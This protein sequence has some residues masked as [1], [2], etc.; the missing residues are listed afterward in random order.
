M[1]SDRRPNQVWNPVFY[2][3]H[4]SLQI[5]DLRRPA[6]TLRVAFGALRLDDLF[7][8][9]LCGLHMRRRQ[10]QSH[11]QREE[12]ICSPALLRPEDSWLTD[13]SRVL[14]HAVTPYYPMSRSH[15]SHLS[16]INQEI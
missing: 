10:R 14:Y 11:K 13:D 9:S 3:W 12:K 5:T 8:I 4:P 7:A 1:P 6:D 15:L 2:A 16:L